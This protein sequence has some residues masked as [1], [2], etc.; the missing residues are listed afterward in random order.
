MELGSGLPL[1][2]R[3]SPNL[4]NNLLTYYY[5]RR[6]YFPLSQARCRTS[7]P[8]VTAIRR[9]YTRKK[10]IAQGAYDLIYWKYARKFHN[11]ILMKK[12]I[13]FFV[14][15]S[16]VFQPQYIHA[17]GIDPAFNS[18]ILIEDHRFNDT[19]T[20]GGPEGIQ[21]FLESKGSVLSNT[22]PEFLV[23]LHEPTDP[24]LKQALG[25]PGYASPR[26]RSA[27]E[28]IWDAAQS[29]G[30]NPQVLLV[31]LNKEQGLITGTFNEYTL[32]R[33]LDRALGFDCPDNSGCGKLFPG[34]YYQF[35]GNV[36][37]EGNRYLGAAKSLMKSFNQPNGRGPA[38]N[39]RP[40]QVGETITLYNTL[41]GYTGVF[42]KQ[43]VTLLNNAT[44]ALYRYTPH[45]FN[46]NYNF[47]RFFNAWFKYANGMLL[48]TADSTTTYILQNG[49]LQS[50]PPF[51]AQARG[52]DFSKVT[53]VSPSEFSNFPIGTVYS[54]ADNTLI[55]VN[56]KT[57]VFLDGVKHP[58]SAF[59][60]AQ[61]NIDAGTA[62]FISETDASLFPDGTQLTPQDDTVLKMDGDPNIYLVKHGKLKLFSWF[63]F[64]QHKA[65]KKIQTIPADE[66]A[67]YPKEGYVAPLDGTLVKSALT[68]SVYLVRQGQ[69]LP[70]TEEL[71]KNHGYRAKNIVTLETPEELSSLPL[72]VPPEPKE[73]TFFAIAGSNELYL[74]KSG[75]KHPISS[76]VAKQRGITPDYFF[77]ASLAVNWADGIVV[78]PKDG[79]LLK[80]QHS[81]VV[82][83]VVNGQLQTLTLELFKNRKFKFLQVVTLGDAEVD[84]LP[85]D[86]FATPSENT[87]FSVPKTKEFYLFRNGEKN[88]IYPIVAKQRSMTPDFAFPS[89]VADDWKEG[90]PIM[91][92]DYTVLKGDASATVYLALGKKLRPF[93][94]LALKR[95]GY[96]KKKIITVPQ[97]EIDTYPKGDI[98]SR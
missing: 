81:P 95:R 17:Q 91:P 83:I 96:S 82:Y 26:L 45:V 56:G 38:A 28:L 85:K 43:A 33:A 6:P 14:I 21:K 71:F 4:T 11:T 36:D 87:Y 37:T 9:E 18:N 35:L 65:A 22:N 76:F 44:A 40:A 73:G 3:A 50:I 23:K 98:I 24:A 80:A 42:V 19:Q 74:F 97:T 60:L 12:G 62:L 47:W 5:V 72:G 25:D 20:F 31:T 58:A 13:I 29:S 7:L 78:P 39:G 64:Q 93:S 88:R 48:K 70:L 84:T 61:R 49:A 2:Q 79:T 46:G 69:R 55:A 15:A 57:Y 8:R 53:I 59:V 67:S 68:P 89:S 34:F 63:T 41:G 92:K 27:A 94:T 75:A 30:I 32:Q 66:L 90:I 52:I 16:L 51:V 77:E 10:E 1:F 54:P 86:G